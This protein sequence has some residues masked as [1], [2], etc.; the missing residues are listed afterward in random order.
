MLENHTRLSAIIGVECLAN[1]VQP[2]PVPRAFIAQNRTVAAR[3][4]ARTGCCAS[5]AIR[6]RTGD[7]KNARAP[8]EGSIQSDHFIPDHL[9]VL[10][11]KIAKDFGDPLGDSRHR[12]AGNSRRSRVHVTHSGLV[13]D[14]SQ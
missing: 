13:E 1:A 11:P 14:V 5:D 6:S 12:G 2:D 7:L 10:D 4:L 9:G 3:A 8:L